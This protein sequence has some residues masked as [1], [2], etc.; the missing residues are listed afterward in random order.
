MSLGTTYAMKRGTLSAVLREDDIT[1][2]NLARIFKVTQSSV[3]LTSDQGV[4]VFPSTSGFF[5]CLDLM[6]GG[7]TF[8]VMGDEVCGA[9]PGPVTNPFHPNPGQSRP[10][11]SF[12]RSATATAARTPHPANSPKLYRRTIF[13]GQLQGEKIVQEKALVI[14]FEESE[15]SLPTLPLAFSVSGEGF[16]CDKCREVVRLTEKILEL[17]SRIQSLFEDSSA[18]WKQSSR[19]LFAINEDVFA[20]MGRRKRR[21][22]GQASRHEGSELFE[23]R[24]KIEEVL[25]ASEGL[26]AVSAKLREL[27]KHSEGLTEQQRVMNSPVLARCCRS[28]VG[29]RQ[30]VDVLLQEGQACV[31]CRSAITGESL[32]AVAGLFE[33]LSVIRAIEQ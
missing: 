24:D 23:I 29:C 1:V 26:P 17:E 13:L 15:A 3:Y 11:F 10:R 20:E 5:S 8:Q 7:G 2:D 30:C 32:V 18:Y 4:S 19:R 31:K 6:T 25:L 16:T 14:P 9:L 12:S 27:C 33:V 21:K 28:L 22:L